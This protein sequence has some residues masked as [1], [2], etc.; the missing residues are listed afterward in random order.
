[1]L[2]DIFDVPQTLD[3]F[4]C[5]QGIYY[6]IMNGFILLCIFVIN[7]YV[8]FFP[9]VNDTSNLALYLYTTQI[10]LQSST[11]IQNCKLSLG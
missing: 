6:F 10:L 7:S 9:I 2:A 5:L 3:Y 4:I 11:C 1:M 8:G